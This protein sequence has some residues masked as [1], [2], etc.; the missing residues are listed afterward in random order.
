VD[1]PDTPVCASPDVEKLQAEV[2]RL[3]KIIRVLVERAERSAG[4]QDSDFNLFQT[5]LMLEKRVNERTAALRKALDEND[6]IT[7]SLRQATREL[8]ASHAEQQ[9]LI[10]ELRATQAQLLA[11]EAELR[12]HRDHLSDLVV[13]QTADLLKAK[14]AA[15]HA[16]AMKSEFLANMSHELRTPL[17]A[18]A[19]Y[20]ELGASRAG[21]APPEKLGDYFSKI[22]VAG[23]RLHGLVEK[24]LDMASYEARGQRLNLALCDLREILVEIEAEQ[25]GLLV[26]QNLT[27][28]L[29]IKAED[30]SG[31]LDRLRIGQVLRVLYGNAIRYSAPGMS[32][33]ILLTRLEEDQGRRSLMLRVRDHGPGIPAGEEAHIFEPFAQS[34]ATKTGAGGVGLGLS[35]AREIVRLHQGELTARNAPDGGAIFEL[36]LPG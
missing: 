11:S 27:V 13:E 29:E 15:E 19:S 25:H 21:K 2:I 16:N 30:C 22:T 17:H 26:A 10:E 31:M 14:N 32:I 20:A 5:T 12:R 24:L 7:R 34:S 6:A 36:I 28:Q 4:M 1:K 3:H 8:A 35:L 23:Q 9:F 33:D 18:I